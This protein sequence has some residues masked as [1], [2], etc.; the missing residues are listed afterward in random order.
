MN[1]FEKEIILENDHVLLRNL[2]RS[3]IEELSKI[4]F[5][6]EIW[7]YY[8]AIVTN[9]KEFEAWFNA[10]EKDY[11]A[12]TRIPFFVFDKRK[13]RAAGSTSYMNIAVNDKRLEIGTTWYGKDF[14]GTGLNKHCK[15]L[16]LDYAFNTLGCFRVEFKADNLNERSKSAMRKI[17][18]TEEGV[19]RSHMQMPYG[20]RRDTVY[21]SIIKSEWDTIK[22]NIFKELF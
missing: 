21:F 20:R 18:A 1:I 22:N 12:K 19:F 5:D 9:E 2:R 7:K 13:N 11:V 8:P 4:T 10:M 14:R 15:F 3:D 17:G 6:E 16:L